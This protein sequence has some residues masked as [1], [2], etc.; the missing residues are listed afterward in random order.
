MEK[1][2]RTTVRCFSGYKANERPLAFQYGNGEILVRKVV[3]S[4]REPDRLCFKVMA[5][6]AHTYLLEHHEQYDTWQVKR[7]FNRL[8]NRV[9]KNCADRDEPSYGAVDERQR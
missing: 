1:W 7:V 6:D 5:D 8:R 4:W 2:A 9:T 3:E